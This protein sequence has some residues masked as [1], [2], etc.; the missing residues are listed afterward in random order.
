MPANIV[1]LKSQLSVILAIMC[2][3]EIADTVGTVLNPPRSVGFKRKSFAE[4]KAI[5]GQLKSNCDKYLPKCNIFR[6]LLAKLYADY[7][8]SGEMALLLLEHLE[9]LKFCFPPKYSQHQLDEMLKASHVL[10]SIGAFK[11]AKTMLDSCQQLVAHTFAFS[12]CPFQDR[13]DYL[14]SQIS[15]E[16]NAMSYVA[17][18]H[19][20]L[21]GP[22]V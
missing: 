9:S 3:T 6:G 13:I 10:A 1:E 5:V 14:K 17:W 21:Y 2:M 20:K 7:V 15:S 12:P 4:Q 22:M 16:S 18:E 19:A 8:E 11:K